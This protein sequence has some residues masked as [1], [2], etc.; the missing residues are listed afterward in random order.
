MKNDKYK[1]LVLSDL[2]EKSAQALSYAAK[3][4]NEIDANVELFY[5]KEATEIM[6]TENPLSAMR[7][8]SEVCNQTDKKVKDLVTPISKQNYIKIKTTFAFGNVKNEI[9]N[10]INMSQ[11][12]MIIMGERKQKRFNFLGD[13][14]TRLVKN[15][16]EGVVFVATDKT[17]LDSKGKVS[18]DNL[19]LKNNI[20]NYNVKDELMA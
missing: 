13:N 2:K 17:I 4:S 5:V 15:N 7:I 12:D 11:P 20:A 16:F 14:I 1:I 10:S 3:L 9:K 18:L 6:Q 8:L 19:G